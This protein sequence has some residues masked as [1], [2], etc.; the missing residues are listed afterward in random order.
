MANK[1]P[2]LKHA[3]NSRNDDFLYR[4]EDQFGAFGYA[5]WWK[6]LEILHQHGTGDKFKM[7]TSRLCLELRSK[8]PRVRLYLG[9]SQAAGKLQ[10]QFTRDGVEIEI[11]NFRK[12]QNNLR[13]KAYPKRSQIAQEGEGE[14]EG[15]NKQQLTAVCKNGKPKT[16][17]QLVVEFFASTVGTSI[18]NQA[19]AKRFFMAH[20]KAASELLSMASGDVELAKVAIREISAYLNRLVEEKRI[21]EWSNLAAI[22]NQFVKW[23]T[24]YDRDKARK[25]N[26]N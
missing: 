17:H 24:E 18:E 9:W 4:A 16:N 13:V 11:K 7:T 5:A 25:S 22:N 1:L 12:W 6:I 15:D 2:W 21:N 14:G 8:L 23:K 3:A 26:V 20:G 19:I 10:H